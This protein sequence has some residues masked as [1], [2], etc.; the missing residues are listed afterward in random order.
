MNSRV[1]IGVASLILA[2]C[3]SV[4]SVPLNPDGTDATANSNKVKG[5]RYYIPKPYLLVTAL[6]ASPASSV[7]DA[8]LPQ[9]HK[10]PEAQGG[11]DTASKNTDT[12]LPQSNTPTANASDTSFTAA[13][14]QYVVKL[15]YLPDYSQPMALQMHSGM[16]GTVSEAP[17]LQDGWMLTSM[18][19]SSN[20]GV[21][22]ALSAIAS[23]VSG[24][25]GGAATSTARN[26]ATSIKSGNQSVA[27]EKF[28]P[29]AQE[30]ASA[31]TPENRAKLYE[32]LGEGVASG[33]VDFSDDR[34]AG[35]SQ[36]DMKALING[37]LSAR[38]AAKS[39]PANILAP[40]LYEFDYEPAKAPGSRIL[41]GL[42]PIALFC[43]NGT[44]VAA[45]ATPA[46]DATVTINKADA[47]NCK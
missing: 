14:A 22:D 19:G 4:T 11:G 47:A 32:I 15:I 38:E 6:P 23:I 36:A 9:A 27:A 39:T 13:T 29:N 2:S 21:A 12:Q 35:L 37:I 31:T 45:T 17:T 33:S 1:L 10:K 30:L 20:S 46:S 24:A 41:T 28:T 5:I 34:L 16:F 43:P 8:T 42:K 7:S 44:V 26:A 25:K 3:A 40:G 18:S